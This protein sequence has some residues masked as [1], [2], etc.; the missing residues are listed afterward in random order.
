MILGKNIV[1]KNIK[2]S[3]K[4]IFA[5]TKYQYFFKNLKKNETF[6][7]SK[8]TSY[9]IYILD[10]NKKKEIFIN[11]KKLN[12]SKGDIL[13][14]ENI[15]TVVRSFCGNLKLLI[16]GTIKSK[17]KEKKIKITKKSNIYKVNK[18]WGY[19]LWLNGR[20]KNYSFKKIFL[21]K[22]FRTSLQFH[23]KKMETN[24]IF[25]GMAE[26][27]YKNSGAIDNLEVTK[28][29]ISFKK[30]SSISKIFVKPNTIHR[31]KALTNLMLYEASTP[32]L[33]DVIRISD[34]FNRKHGLIKKEHKN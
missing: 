29:D 33:D 31:I 15:E 8:L 3:R 24:I 18:P 17:L 14:I 4:V 16:V 32:E 10:I 9:S 5:K 20:H 26:L 1:Q 19:E 30:L 12:I 2:L 13:Q 23:K 34:D 22:N 28:K 11:E 21:K 7:I 6:K 27:S 25:D